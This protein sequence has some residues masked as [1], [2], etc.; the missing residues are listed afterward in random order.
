[1]SQFYLTV[2]SDSG[3]HFAELNTASKFKVHLGRVIELSGDWEVA[4]F[5]MFYPETFDNVRRG[6]C[7]IKKEMQFMDSANV[8]RVKSKF[9]L[10]SGFYHTHE[11]LCK[12]LNKCTGDDTTMHLEFD[13]DTN[14]AIIYANVLALADEETTYKFSNELSDIL[15]F[16]RS[17]IIEGTKISE[18][19]IPCDLRKGMAKTLKIYSDIIADQLINNT[20]A[21]LLREVHLN[22]DIF[23][24][25]FQQH[26]N[27]ERLVF[28]PVI[29]KNL[30]FLEFHIKDEQ[31]REI[32]F[33][34][35][36]LKLILLF[37][38]AGNGF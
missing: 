7:L 15:G 4:L 36:T 35:G 14:K 6:S 2:S 28:L 30:E 8:L 11:N 10:P 24:F 33:S 27:F 16:H 12:A 18:G 32:S 9:E 22:P 37:R 26:R 23:K 5:E 1:M 20:H 29:K 34:H 17:L 21:Q 13:N 38:R 3:C 25:G 19:V 31:D